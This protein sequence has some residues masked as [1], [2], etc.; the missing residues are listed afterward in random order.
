MLNTLFT[1]LNS[2]KLTDLTCF[3][4]FVFCMNTKIKAWRIGTA[5]TGPGPFQI[6][7]GSGS[8]TAGTS[9]WFHLSAFTLLMSRKCSQLGENVACCDFLL[10]HLYH[11]ANFKNWKLLNWNSPSVGPS[12]TPLL[13]SPFWN[14]FG[15]TII[16]S[17]HTQSAEEPILCTIKTNVFPYKHTSSGSAQ[18]EPSVNQLTCWVYLNLHHWSDDRRRTQRNCKY[19]R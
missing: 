13:T 2:V 11:F 9:A 14:T 6:R 15:V 10:F 17:T 8:G 19:K 3:F 5:A 7:R 16:T 12:S 4:V 18:C 1:R